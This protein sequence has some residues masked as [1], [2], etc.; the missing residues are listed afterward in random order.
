MSEGRGAFTD[1]NG[2]YK[3]PTIVDMDKEYGKKKSYEKM[4]FTPISDKEREKL[5]LDKES[6]RNER[7]KMILESNPIYLAKELSHFIKRDNNVLSWDKVSL[8]EALKDD[9]L[10]YNM[11]TI[12]EKRMVINLPD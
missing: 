3:Q 1:R 6:Y 10:L 12:L 4:L 9:L 7:I 11:H 5:R 8:S 2:D